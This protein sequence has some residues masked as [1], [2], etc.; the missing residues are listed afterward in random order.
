MQDLK[1]DARLWLLHTNGET[2]AVI[3]LF[4]TEEKP[5]PGLT[6]EATIPT[7]G[8]DNEATPHTTTDDETTLPTTVSDH[9]VEISAIAGPSAT[10]PPMASLDSEENL[11]DSID[12]TTEVTDLSQR[13]FILNEQG[14]LQH[15]LLGNVTA[16][17]HIF[18]AS[19]EGDD[20]SET[21]S[22]TLLPPEPEASEAPK[23]FEITLGDM[24]GNLALK[25]QEKHKITFELE[26]LKEVVENSFPKTAR[27]RAT[28]RANK[29]LKETLG[30]G[31]QSTFAQRKRQ[32]LG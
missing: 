25:G 28:D 6:S 3:V 31:E 30:L 29:L 10:V 21:F 15:P 24:L 13:L 14:K 8:S 19:K 2:K 11:I 18:K 7:S 9:E 4:F 12:E 26:D 1:Q 20:I 5:K 22:A 23:V 16:S 32:R 17:L 27:L